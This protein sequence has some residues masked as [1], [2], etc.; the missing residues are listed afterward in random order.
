M[1]G[2]EK[3]GG[4]KPIVGLALDVDA[5]PAFLF[6]SEDGRFFGVSLRPHGDDLPPDRRWLRRSKFALGVHEAVP[7]AIDPE[8]LLRGVKANGYFVWTANR[9]QPFGTAQ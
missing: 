3:H 5:T 4:L 9:T 6:E 2:D 8:P 7:A 1:T